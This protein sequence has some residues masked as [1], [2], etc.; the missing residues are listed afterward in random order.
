MKEF[1][2]SKILYDSQ[3][4]LPAVICKQ[5]QILEEFIVRKVDSDS[6]CE[7]WAVAYT[8]E[9]ES[10]GAYLLICTFF[11]LFQNTVFYVKN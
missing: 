11:H 8:N 3:L 9:S 1:L 6:Q 2:Y 4:L 5:N 7:I 10:L